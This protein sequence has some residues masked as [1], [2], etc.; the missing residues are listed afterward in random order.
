MYKSYTKYPVAFS[1]SKNEVVP[2]DEVTEENRLSLYCPTCKTNFIAV[3]NHRTPHFKHKPNTSCSGTQETYLHWLSKE[4][5]KEIKEIEIPELHIDDLPEKQ[6][7]KFQL[8]FNK[9][10]DPNVPETFRSIFKKSLK[11]NLINSRKIVLDNIEIEKEFKTT[12]GNIRVDVVAINKGKPLFIEPFFTNP[13]DKEKEGKISAIGIATLSLDLLKFIEFYGQNYTVEILKKYLISKVG[14]KW[15]YLGDKVFDEHIEC[16]MNYL[17]NEVEE[18]KDTINFHQSTQIKIST[19]EEECNNK[20]GEIGK[21]KDEI[22]DLQTEIFEL[23][24]AIGIYY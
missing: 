22:D 20:Y 24:N 8:K 5:F 14:K 4:L 13:I 9:I 12:Y 1:F 16:Y 7:Q 6:R 19:L 3:L 10:I 23:K 17:L 15:V 2:I 21:L 18:N 11:K